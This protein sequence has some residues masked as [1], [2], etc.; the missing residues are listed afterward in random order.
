MLMTQEDDFDVI[1]GMSQKDSVSIVIVT[2]NNTPQGRHS[3]FV[4]LP[5]VF[6]IICVSGII[7]N[8]II[9]FV[10]VR[11]YKTTVANVYILNLASADLFFLLTLPFTAYRNTGRS[12]I[13]GKIACKVVHGIDGM[14]MFLGLFTLTALSID[15]YLALVHTLKS[16]NLRT[17]RNARIV[18]ASLWVMSALATLPLWLYATTSPFLDTLVFCEIVSPANIHIHY[19]FTIYS[20]IIGFCLPLI[21]ITFCYL[22]VIKKITQ[23]KRVHLHS[24]RI[25][26]N[27]RN[28]RAGRITLMAR[29]SAI[30]GCIAHKCNENDKCNTLMISITFMVFVKFM[31]NQ[32]WLQTMEDFST[33]ALSPSLKSQ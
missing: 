33:V 27:K 13:F 30:E 10:L 15:R 16:R 25:N 32:R 26:K 23:A 29:F 7:G 24:K 19:V 11:C 17:V 21:I 2:V 14:N 18:C 20:F 9:I 22:S 1:E 31:G 6:G 8:G 3:L 12:W 28:F 4:I 5:T